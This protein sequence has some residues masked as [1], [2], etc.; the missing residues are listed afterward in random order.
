MEN[1]KI[2]IFEIFYIKIKLQQVIN[3]LNP[4]KFIKLNK[5]KLL[6]K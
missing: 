6:S 2:S 3:F 5:T 4:S 1:L